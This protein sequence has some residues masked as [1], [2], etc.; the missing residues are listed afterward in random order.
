MVGGTFWVTPLEWLLYA[1]KYE[2]AVK[3]KSTNIH[4]TMGIVY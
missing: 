2:D 1:N 3:S 4:A